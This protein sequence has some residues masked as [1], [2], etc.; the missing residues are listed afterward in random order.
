MKDYANKLEEFRAAFA[1]E[2]FNR[3]V[4]RT[5]IDTGILRDSWDINLTATSIDIDNSAPYSAYVEYGTWK[6]APRGMVRTTVLEAEQITKLAK[7]RAGL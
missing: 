5:P 6:M 4:N 1:E 2:F 3:V 7:E